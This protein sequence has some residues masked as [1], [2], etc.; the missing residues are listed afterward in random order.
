VA[1][2]LVLPN[3][4]VLAGGYF[5][6]AGGVAASGIARWDGAAWSADGSAPEIVLAL[7]ATPSDDVFV[8]GGFDLVAGVVSAN[9]AVLATTCPAAAVPF[10]T[11]C[12]GSGGPNVLA[13]DSL[14]WVG[15]T[16]AAT[17][18][19]MP[20]QAVAFSIVGFG[21]GSVPLSSLLP[22]GGAGCD[23]LVSPDH[24][25]L[26]LPTAGAVQATLTFPNTP[27]LAGIELHQQVAPLGLDAQ[28]NL[29]EFTSTNGVT[30][31]IGAF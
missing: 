10:G 14:P 1:A 30:L 17:A 15:S 7:S 27:S 9:A 21:Q 18:T 12:T 16:Y 13:A 2:L 11:G 25:E 29:T 6:S 31:T 3:G 19:G 23:L 26:L 8:G 24:V 22:V 28:L 4:D 5:T 20:A